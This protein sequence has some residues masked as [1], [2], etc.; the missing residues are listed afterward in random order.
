LFLTVNTFH[1]Y[2]SPSEHQRRRLLGHLLV[3]FKIVF[4]LEPSSRKWP[5][6]L[7]LVLQIYVTLKNTVLLNITS[8]IVVGVMKL[9][10]LYSAIK[11]EGCSKKS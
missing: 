8:Y 10:S 9:I 2:P 5:L 4:F 3:R 6:R 1:A 11:N 7:L